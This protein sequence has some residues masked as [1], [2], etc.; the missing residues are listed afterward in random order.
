MLVNKSPW[1][2]LVT[3]ATQ[4]SLCACHVLG[5]VAV[6]QQLYIPVCRG[7]LGLLSV[8]CCVLGAAG[9]LSVAV[10]LCW[11]CPNWWRWWNWAF[12]L[13]HGLFSRWRLLGWSRLYLR[14]SWRCSISNCLFFSRCDLFWICLFNLL[15]M[16]MLIL[17]VF[18]NT[19]ENL[20]Q[21]GQGL[22][23]LL[24]FLFNGPAWAPKTLDTVDRQFNGGTLLKW[25]FSV[26]GDTWLLNWPFDARP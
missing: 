11:G 8:C 16:G 12:Q 1:K 15:D 24:C 2:K 7:L 3:I 9:L 20:E 19:C 23:G 18:F 14:M 21:N 4:P 22:G 25:W 6:W 26:K 5:S 10:C 17:Y 13:Q